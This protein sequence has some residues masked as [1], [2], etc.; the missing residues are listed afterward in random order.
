ML[1][2]FEFQLAEIVRWSS[3]GH[4]ADHPGIG[5]DS[6]AIREPRRGAPRA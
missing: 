2:A 6:I 3:G 4:H 1:K 5:T